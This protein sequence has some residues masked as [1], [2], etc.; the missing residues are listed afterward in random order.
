MQSVFGTENSWS[1]A[2]V[3]PEVGRQSRSAMRMATG[4]GTG[5]YEGKD[6]EPDCHKKL[7]WGRVAN[8]FVEK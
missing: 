2:K 5:S 8:A 6:C 3:V 7:S 1:R 4:V